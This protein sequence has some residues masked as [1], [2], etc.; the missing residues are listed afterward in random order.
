MQ[1]LVATLC[2][3]NEGYFSSGGNDAIYGDEEDVLFGDK[4]TTF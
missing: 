4:G 3:G 1:V 2:L